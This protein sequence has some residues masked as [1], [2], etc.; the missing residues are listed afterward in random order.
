MSDKTKYTRGLIYMLYITCAALLL[1]DVL[2]TRH[3]YLDFES[4]PGFYI[5]F[6]IVAYIVTIMAAKVLRKFVKRNE[7]YYD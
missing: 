6:G 4:A 7:D 1:I 3:G 5:V 2:F